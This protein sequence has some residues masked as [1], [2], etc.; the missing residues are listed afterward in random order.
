LLILGGAEKKRLIASGGTVHTRGRGM[1]E[2]IP[3]NT[4][5]DQTMIA[6]RRPIA[7][8]V[9][10]ALIAA[11]DHALA[12]SSLLRYDLTDAVQ[13][14]LLSYFCTA[15]ELE[16]ASIALARQAE[17]IGIP[18]LARSMLEAQV[19]FRCLLADPAYVDWI[20]AAHD[21]EWA[22]V[23]DEAITAGG[24]YLGKLGSEPT[25]RLERDRIAKREADRTGKGI[26]KLKAMERFRRA[27]MQELYYSVY[28]F[29]CAES[30]NDAR[31]LIS[32]HIK[33]DSKG[34][35]RLT[36]YADDL[37]FDETSLMQVHDSMSAMTE[38]VC[39]KFSIAEPDRTVVDRTFAAAK[40][41][42]VSIDR[43][44]ERAK[45]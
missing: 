27:S 32:R 4:R 11:R 7:P 42:M 44:A 9:L 20:E 38:G 30:H 41:Y 2:E 22:K 33:E 5:V 3:K 35:I 29:L 26:R 23:I 43:S 31:A 25:V 36:V 28:N 6:T 21:R 10:D 40:R 45:I 14:Y 37:A 12:V 1:N 16:G 34:V 8:P 18:I 15:I 13:R 17:S 39:G 24:A 19:D